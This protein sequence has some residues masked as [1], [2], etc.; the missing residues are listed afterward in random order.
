MTRNMKIK[1]YTF[2]WLIA[3]GCIITSCDN[4]LDGN[5]PEDYAS[6][7][8]FKGIEDEPETEMKI[9]LTGEDAVY[10]IELGKGGN[11]PKAEANV[12]LKIMTEEE[13]KAYNEEWNTDYSLLPAE[14]Y[15]FSETSIKFA[16]DESAK[17][18]QITFKSDIL[19]KLSNSNIQ[20]V[21]P[22]YLVSESNRIHQGLN[23]S[24]LKLNITVPTIKID[25]PEFQSI[26]K[27]LYDSE[28][29]KKINIPVTAI[30][31]LQENK[32]NFNATFVRDTEKLQ[33]LVDEYKANHPE[34]SGYELMPTINYSI[35]E[36]LSFNNS[37]LSD[38]TI[39]IDANSISEEKNY[40]LPIMLDKCV[41]KPFKTDSKV[42]Y[43]HLYMKDKLPE[44]EV[45]P[46]MMVNSFPA[47]VKEGSYGLANLFDNNYNTFWKSR[48]QRSG[49][50]TIPDDNNDGYAQELKDPKYGIWLDIKFN[51]PISYFAF[52]YQTQTQYEKCNPKTIKLYF[53]N[54]EKI[55]DDAQAMFT[56]DKNLPLGSKTETAWYNSVNF[57][58][59]GKYSNVRISIV[60]SH[61]KWLTSHVGGWTGMSE[62]RIYGKE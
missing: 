47:E 10:E 48:W 62:L 15:S 16:S 21:I 33:Q 61:E 19:E 57:D 30:I 2:A 17:K 43:I 18:I 1:L 53:Y 36:M 11:N 12:E 29:D 46:D 49:D 56:I 22:I 55:P 35:P 32:W 9:L 5:L 54:E 41:G 28:E 51:T 24:I 37:L 3:C 7:V 60:E 40:I 6:V 13:L 23:Q 44:I 45:T 38:A 26:E 34:A 59:G 31:D 25:M 8:H 20:Y 27:S 4:A 52:D 50:E 42:F 14:Y 39:S 58:L